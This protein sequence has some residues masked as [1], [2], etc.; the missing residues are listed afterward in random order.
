MCH[1]L[2]LPRGQDLPSNLLGEVLFSDIKARGLLWEWLVRK[3]DILFA[4]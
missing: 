3:W 1:W 4:E 2:E